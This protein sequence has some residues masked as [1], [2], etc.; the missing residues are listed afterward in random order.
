MVAKPI[1][2]LKDLSFA[3]GSDI[4]DIGSGCSC[5]LEVKN[6]MQS[7]QSDLFVFEAISESNTTDG[8]FPTLTL[9]YLY[10]SIGKQAKISFGFTFVVSNQ[11]NQILIHF[12]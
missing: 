11:T 9:P 7:L 5:F 6:L 12:Y 10:Q 8:K 3:V 2:P 4:F 1:C